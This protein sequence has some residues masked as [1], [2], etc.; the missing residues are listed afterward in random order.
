MQS[1]NAIVG[2]ALTASQ[3]ALNHI[4]SDAQTF[5]NTLITAQNTGDVSTLATQAQSFLDS[6]TSYVNTASARRIRFWRNE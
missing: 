6:F 5:M 1:S 3:N 4:S 2:T